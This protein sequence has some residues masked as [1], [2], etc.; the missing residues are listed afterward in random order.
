MET[1][2]QNASQI[3]T[4]LPFINIINMIQSLSPDGGI[5]LNLT[6]LEELDEQQIADCLHNS[7]ETARTKLWKLKRQVQ[8]KLFCLSV[9]TEEI[10]QN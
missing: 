10:F 7:P 6:V 9:D 4:I 2:Y 3:S 5:I 1:L 8:N